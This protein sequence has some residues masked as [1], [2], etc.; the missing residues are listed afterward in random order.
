VKRCENE[1][2]YSGKDS[3]DILIEANVLI[4]DKYN[5]L[6]DKTW[7]CNKLAR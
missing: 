5:V 4:I 6:L 3:E 2:R 1:G 7:Q